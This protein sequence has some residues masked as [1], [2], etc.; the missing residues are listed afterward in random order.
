MRSQQVVK[1]ILAGRDLNLLRQDFKYTINLKCGE[2]FSFHDYKIIQQNATFVDFKINFRFGG[3]YIPRNRI[4]H[5]GDKKIVIKR[6][7]RIFHDMIKSTNVPEI[8]TKEDITKEKK[9]RVKK[10]V[11]KEQIV[12]ILA[13]QLGRM[14]TE[15]EITNYK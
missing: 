7:T 11:P 14:P 13:I 6:Y 12:G 10:A 4:R 8:E 2:S 5:R 3:I 1:Y 9:K 15:E